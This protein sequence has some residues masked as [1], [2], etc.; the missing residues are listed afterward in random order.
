[1]RDIWRIVWAGDG[2]VQR[3][4]GPSANERG[5]GGRQAIFRRSSVYVDSTVINLTAMDTSLRDYHFDSPS[6]A[7]GTY[8]CIHARVT[9]HMR[10]SDGYC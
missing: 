5:P 9:M 8:S 7:D 6:Y 1:M 4:K 2:R 10:R 3:E